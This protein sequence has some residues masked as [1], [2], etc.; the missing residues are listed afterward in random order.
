MV[1]NWWVFRKVLLIFVR[2]K[3]EVEWEFGQFQRIIED[4]TVN[5]YSSQ[6]SSILVAFP[7]CFPILVDCVSL[8]SIL[9][10]SS[11]FECHSSQILV[12]F[13]QF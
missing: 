9:V 12:L 10:H 4:L 11:H 6:R 5:S 1:R 13:K 8:Q 3:G 2:L 7:V